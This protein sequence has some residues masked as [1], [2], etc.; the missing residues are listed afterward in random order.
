MVVDPKKALQ[1]SFGGNSCNC[2]SKKS[3]QY[4]RIVSMNDEDKSQLSYSEA[5]AHSTDQPVNL[6]ESVSSLN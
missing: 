6:D 4:H 1:R 2:D 5:S 3:N